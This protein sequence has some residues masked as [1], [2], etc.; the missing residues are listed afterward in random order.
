M[1]WTL[2]D[3]RRCYAAIAAVVGTNPYHLQLLMNH[4]PR[5]N[6]V[7]AGYV[8][9]LEPEDLQASQQAITDRLV[10]LGLRP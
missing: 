1:P 2:H 6:D 7:T 9:A 3:L 8:G 10:K 4:A 5:A